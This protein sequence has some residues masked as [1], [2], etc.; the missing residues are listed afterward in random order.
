MCY[1]CQVCDT[2]VRGPMR[3]HVV[4]RV[5]PGRPVTVIDFCEDR[6]GE[7]RRTYRTVQGEPR[8]EVVREIPACADCQ[9]KLAQGQK[10]STIKSQLQSSDQ[11]HLLG[12]GN[13]KLR[14]KRRRFAPTF[15]E[16][17]DAELD[18]VGTV[19]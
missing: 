12:S 13:G 18:Q 10:I 3:R 2:V 7:K 17:F 1:R 8:R 19:S 6:F 15:A 11:L 9:Q 5:T 16:L 14:N 4:E